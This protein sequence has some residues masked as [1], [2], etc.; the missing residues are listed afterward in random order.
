MQMEQSVSLLGQV[1]SE[2]DED[3]KISREAPAIE[4]AYISEL[5]KCRY[6]TEGLAGFVTQIPYRLHEQQKNQDH[7]R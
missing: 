3:E 2:Y 6:P 5:K 4:E 7:G 1:L